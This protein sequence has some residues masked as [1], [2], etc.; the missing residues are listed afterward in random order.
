MCLAQF[1][2]TLLHSLGW[3]RH[4]GT[5]SVRRK[6]CQDLT[7]AEGPGCRSCCPGCRAQTLSSF[8]G[9]RQN[10]PSNPVLAKALPPTRCSQHQHA[11]WLGRDAARRLPCHQPGAP[12]TPIRP[13]QENAPRRSVTPFPSGPLPPQGTSQ[14]GWGEKRERSLL[15]ACDAESSQQSWCLL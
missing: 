10:L 7:R 9:R 8:L 13:C 6:Q 4:A 14:H 5:H 1:D 15:V 3:P 12:A 11:Q 2:H